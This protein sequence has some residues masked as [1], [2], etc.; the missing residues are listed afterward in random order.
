MN[1]N[2]PHIDTPGISAVR[3]ARE[4]LG[5]SI[6]TTPVWQFRSSKLTELLG[7]HFCLWLKLEL[8]QYGGSFKLRAALLSLASLNLEQK[9]KG[10]C[11][12]SAGNHAIA[13]SWAAKQ[14]GVHAKVLMPKTASPVRISLC[15]SLGAEV[16]LMQNMEEV[17]SQAVTIQTSEGRT[18]IHPFDGAMVSLGTGT[19]GL[20]IHEQLGELDY[21]LAG[22][23]GGGLIGG[24][25]NACKQLQPSIKIIGVEPVGSAVM[26]QSL[27]ANKPM[28]CIPQSIADSL[29]VPKTEWQPLLMCRRWVDKISTV[30]D[31]AIIAAMRFLFEEM[32]LVAEPAA[33]ISLAAVMGPLRDELKNKKICIILSGTNID[34]QRFCQLLG[35]PV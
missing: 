19:L 24:V 34:E 7:A 10:V 20:E 11:A 13:V 17:F 28:S 22:V 15:Q 23:G 16:V 5:N 3:Q 12:I 25:A 21:I 1:S 4:F 32:K 9:Q 30:N 26:Q 29:C 27:A 6:L 33:A 8:W 2:P 18:L 31:A 35:T 14:Y